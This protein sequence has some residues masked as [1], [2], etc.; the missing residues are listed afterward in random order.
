RQVVLFVSWTL[1]VPLVYG[2]GLEAVGV[3]VHFPSPCAVLIRK[4]AH[5]GI[6]ASLSTDISRMVVQQGV[7]GGGR[8]GDDRAS[9]ASREPLR[10]HLQEK[11]YTLELQIH[12]LV[13]LLFRGVMQFRHETPAGT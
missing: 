10:E 4:A 5:E 3:R 9:T 6:G 2:L 13:D 11:E 12:E 8:H 7:H 1:L